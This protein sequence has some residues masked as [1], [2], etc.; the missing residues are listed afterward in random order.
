M[1]AIPRHLYFG[2]IA[3]EYGFLSAEQVKRC[4]AAQAEAKTSG[5]TPPPLGRV[6]LELKLLSRQQA[7][8]LLAI[9][10]ELIEKWKRGE[11]SGAAGEEAV[12][13]PADP[14][15]AKEGWV[16]AAPRRSSESAVRLKGETK[17][18]LATRMRA[19]AAR[20]RIAFYWGSAVVYVA[21]R[22][23]AAALGT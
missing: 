5:R 4:L 18:R 20:S 23:L 11:D 14:S 15:D 16:Q 9:Q 10:K 1:A 13:A 8:L 6:A 7:E 19:R 2:S 22:V 3:I 21:L 12:S 17:R